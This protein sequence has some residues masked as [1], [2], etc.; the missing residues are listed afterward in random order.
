MQGGGLCPCAWRGEVGFRALEGTVPPP[1]QEEM[2][3][4]L[5]VVLAARWAWARVLGVVMTH[6]W[7]LLGTG[8][9]A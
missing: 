8:G 1:L 6:G 7:L 3:L 5:R 2:R 9:G 4:G